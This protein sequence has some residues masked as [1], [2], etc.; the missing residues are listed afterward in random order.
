MLED[1]DIIVDLA[2]PF[3]KKKKVLD[4]LDSIDTFEPVLPSAALGKLKK[5][6]KKEEKNDTTSD[7][8]TSDDEPSIDW[9][10]A[11]CD[12][13]AIKKKKKK[14]SFSFDIDDNG[15]V[16]GT[17]KKKKKKGKG[18]AVKNYAREFE[19]ELGLLR[20]LYI[21]QSKFTDSLQKKYDAM[22]STKSTA[23]G[24]GKFTTDLITTISAAR[25][26]QLAIVKEQIAT[27]QKI[28]DL[29]FKERKEFAP[30]ESGNDDNA[31][32]ASTF[33]NELI[34]NGRNNIVNL[35]N[36]SIYD[37]AGTFDDD[38]VAN[39]LVSGLI[40]SDFRSSDADKFIEYENK[41]V[42]VLVQ[43]NDEGEWNFIARDSD[44]NIVPDYP[45]PIKT[46]MSF[47]RSTMKAT[48][49]YGRKFDMEI[50]D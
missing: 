17:E 18:G 7:N 25:S 29:N 45:L 2:P 24:V 38:E 10:S 48:D 1:E 41:N 8:Q 16:V 31:M 36:P 20:N 32:Y 11:I 12:T 40:D 37:N 43:V 35:D 49:A 15:N 23:R 34:K 47:N 22:N 3:S 39:E 28:A 26:T 46:K 19:T 27:K 21:D 30:K 5:S 33:M 6:K 14:H 50:V 44:G 13:K 9:I 4:D 42:S